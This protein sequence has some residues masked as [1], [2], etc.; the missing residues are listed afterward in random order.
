[1]FCQQALLDKKSML[2]AELQQEREQG[3]TADFHSDCAPPTPPLRTSSER[4]V[5]GSQ[6]TSP[7]QLSCN[8]SPANT[9][10]QTVENIT[11]ENDKARILG[12]VRST[13]GCFAFGFDN[14]LERFT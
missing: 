2:G 12:M 5:R 8:E 14:S 10:T 4:R 13:F 7:G 1:V 11:T 9:L 3:S 6:D